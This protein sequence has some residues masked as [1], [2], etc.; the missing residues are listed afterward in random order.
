M[1]KSPNHNLDPNSKYNLNVRIPGWLKLE[2]IEFCAE[3]GWS[4]QDWASV[5][6]LVALREGRGLPGEPR[7]VVPLPTTADEIRSHL[8]GERLLGPCGLR[9][10]C[11]FDSGE[12]RVVGGCEFCGVCGVRV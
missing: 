3:N 9:W 7:A 5:R 8:S 2:I 10:P 11:G 4:L 1:P 12:V 6:L